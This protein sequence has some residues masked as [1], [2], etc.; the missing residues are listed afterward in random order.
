MAIPRLG[1]FRHNPVYQSA[2]D[3]AL[4]KESTI[5]DFGPIDN[6]MDIKL[7]FEPE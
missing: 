6:T 2:F 1:L 4:R 3:I 5:V 7:T